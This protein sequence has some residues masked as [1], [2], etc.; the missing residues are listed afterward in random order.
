MEK[1]MQ[2]LV[3]P[4]SGFN[5]FVTASTSLFL[6]T[7][8]DTGDEG[9]DI[10]LDDVMKTGFSNTSL[11]RIRGI[12]NHKVGCAGQRSLPS[13]LLSNWWRWWHAFTGKV[14]YD[15]WWRCLWRIRDA[16]SYVAQE[17][18]LVAWRN[19]GDGVVNNICKSISKFG[20]VGTVRLGGLI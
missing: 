9:E 16:N 17:V 11:H 2:K 18:T 20:K 3:W 8:L 1:S 12:W 13:N 4:K 6:K 5:S 10:D 15:A 19:D 7:V 14:F